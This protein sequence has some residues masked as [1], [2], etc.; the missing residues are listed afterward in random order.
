MVGG[1][2]RAPIASSDTVSLL[3]CVRSMDR[4]SYENYEVIVLEDGSL[5]DTT[6]A[7]IET[8]R[9]RCVTQPATELHLASRVNVA[10]HQAGGAHVVICCDL[11]EVR[12]G[13][14]LTSM[15]EYSE[16]AAIGAVGA[17]LFYP[18]G[19]LRHVGVVL[20]VGGVAAL[21]FHGFPGSSAGYLSSAMGVRNYSAVSGSC[22]MTRRA[23]FDE[24]GGFRAAYGASFGD[25]DYCLRMPRAGY[26]VVFT[27]YAEL[28]YRGL[29]AGP[30]LQGDAR[31]AAEMRRVWRDVLK[32][33][34]FYNQNLTTEFID[35][36]P[37]AGR[38][39]E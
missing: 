7:A 18:D 25:L 26:R 3:R 19:R 4:T 29:D 12:D 30:T 13:E 23:V 20:G 9:S 39:D 16:Q 1:S 11:V 38:S 32:S 24:V 35:Y 10:V 8:R 36:R 21:P 2:A 31:G 37:R 15:L 5:S 14:W 27:P 17:K 6:R 34:P 22:L 28:Y 33:D